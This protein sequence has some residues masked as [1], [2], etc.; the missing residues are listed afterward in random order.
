MVAAH[1]PK[2]PTSGRVDLSGR[3]FTRH[4]YAWY[5]E[6]T[7]STPVLEGRISV[8]KMKLVTRYEDCRFVLSDPRFVRNRGLAK[9][10]P[11]A[12]AL[13][14]PMPKSVA[15]VAKSMIYEDGTAHLRLRTL[16]NK[17]FRSHSVS[18]F[19]PRLT[20]MTEELLD[21]L[22]AAADREEHVDL[23]RGYARTIPTRVIAEMM[24]LSFEEAG[25]FDRSLRVLTEGFSGW[26]L[27]RTLL[28]DLRQTTRFVREIIE[29]KSKQ[30]GDDILTALIDVE[31]EGERLHEDEL[32]AM[33]FLLMIAG[34]ETTMHLIT[35]GVRALIEHPAELE[36]VLKD[37]ALWDS[38]VDE[39]VRF[40]G[41]V[42]GTKPQYPV[43]D[44]EVSG[45]LIP[46][47]TAVMPLLGAANH[48]PRVFDHPEIFD[49]GRTPNHHLGFGFGV[50]FC[51]GKQLA[52]MEA[53]IAL[54]GLFDRFPNTRLAVPS[55][56][57]EIVNMPGWHRH[58][59][60]PVTLVR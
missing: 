58:A 38:A 4:K 24:G 51:L 45:V 32:V 37:P 52:L 47:G 8:L 54:R 9:G 28:W 27:I 6:W 33:V 12:G 11:G 29:R 23:V 15:A 60:L 55:A 34:F 48:D 22:E 44:V 50:H 30:P 20:T 10:K 43:E 53:R 36:R 16:V 39:C 13:P 57:L 31:E 59:A 40:R 3:D 42:H 46:R 5:S 14:F 2:A 21:G 7:E 26:G 56:D 49:V 18:V 17:A 1:I 41:P 25:Q 35:N 19:E